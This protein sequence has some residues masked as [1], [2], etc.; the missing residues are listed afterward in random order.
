MYNTEPEPEPAL[1][2]VSIW[3][4]SRQ[5]HRLASAAEDETAFELRN[6]AGSITQVVSFLMK[7]DRTNFVRTSLE[8]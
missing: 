4:E 8:G 2:Y 3:T 6:V 5:T 7:S 1:A